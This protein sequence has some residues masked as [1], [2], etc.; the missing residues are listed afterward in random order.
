[1]MCSYQKI[2]SVSESNLQRF[3]LE[4]SR[5]G[6]AFRTVAT[7]EA[8]GDEQQTTTYSKSLPNSEE[9][10]Y[11][12]LRLEDFDGQIQYS[13][14][15]AIQGA[16]H[17][18]STVYPNPVT[19]QLTLSVQAE[20]AGSGVITIVDA[21]GRQLQTRTVDW[22]SG[23]NAIQIDVSDLASGLYFIHYTNAGERTMVERFF[24]G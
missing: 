12:R 2:E 1:M 15:L 9:I 20:N 5:D 22:N 24:K 4:Q 10:S 19:E 23:F 11:F 21:L 8:Q 3:Y 17:L 18:E 7:I 14:V 16:C 13:K 6:I